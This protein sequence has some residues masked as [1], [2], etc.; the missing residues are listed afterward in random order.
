MP[1]DGN[2]VPTPILVTEFSEHSAMF[3][4]DGRWIVYVSDESGREEIYVRPYPGP[5][6][7]YAVSTEGGREPVW[8]SGGRE[9]FYRNGDKMM[10]VPVQTNPDFSAGTPKVLFEEPY[11]MWFGGGNNYDVTPDGQRLLMIR[12]DTESAPRQIN[13]V[14]NWHEELKRLVPTN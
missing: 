2:G 7:K 14:L 9:I 3:S 6:G 1:V 5:G 13:V 12:R 10:V 4:P 11:A 8:S